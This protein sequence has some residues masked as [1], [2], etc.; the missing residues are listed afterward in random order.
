MESKKYSS[1]YLTKADWVFKT[2]RDQIILGELNPGEK[3]TTVKIAEYLN[4]SETPVREGLKRLEAVGLV[5]INPHKNVTVSNPSI[6][7]IIEKLEIRAYLQSKA[8]LLSGPLLTK[9]DIEIIEEI[10]EKMEGFIRNKN[11]L[12]YIDTGYVFHENIYKRCPNKS[13]FKLIKELKAKTLFAK[14]R[15]LIS[16]KIM[17]WSKEEHLNL[18]KALKEK[19]FYSVSAIEY[20]HQIR[21]IEEFKQV[22]KEKGF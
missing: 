8:A 15:F 22:V 5:E 12:D 14:R 13:L 1:A 11:I 19:D 4:I 17:E 6:E 10:H 21:S 2:L 7:E 18:I 16:S 9:E 3:L 20:E